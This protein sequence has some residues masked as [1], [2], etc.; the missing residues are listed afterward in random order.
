M[1]D[2]STVSASPPSELRRPQ[3]PAPTNEKR[4]SL[5]CLRC[6]TKRARCSGDKPVCRACEK[7]KEECIWPSG[8]RRKR[9]RKEMEEEERRERLASSAADSLGY[10]GRRT[11]VHTTGWTEQMS[12]EP[13]AEPM[14]WDYPAPAWP[15]A[16]NAPTS[17]PVPGPSPSNVA[18]PLFADMR[19]REYPQP[20]PV[21]YHEGDQPTQDDQ[22]YPRYQ[23]GS[24]TQ[25]PA[26]PGLNP[27]SLKFP[28]PHTSLPASASLP[29]FNSNPSPP[30]PATRELDDMFDEIGF[31]YPHLYIPLLDTFFQTMSRHFPSIN[32][33]R[34]E[35][36]LKNVSQE[37]CK[38]GICALAARLVPL[39]SRKHKK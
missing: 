3:S 36:R 38:P 28:G 5:A 37:M 8:R 20:R 25:A 14:S 2:S 13:Y 39:T 10:R 33:K 18:S 30:S 34:I 4:V 16:A 27:L 31:P 26:P 24:S 1:S 32:R 21:S 6:R 7:A 19:N 35:E 11:P 15:H 23:S 12:V 17:H 9:T 29:R 22:Y